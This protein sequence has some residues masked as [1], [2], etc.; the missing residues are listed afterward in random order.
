MKMIR[1][2]MLAS[3]M[4]ASAGLFALRLFF[5]A[6]EAVSSSGFA[7]A[8]YVQM[9]CHFGI[10]LMVSEMSSKRAG[11]RLERMAQTDVLTG[12]GNRRWLVSQLP[13]HLPPGSA[14]L[15]LDLDHFKQINDRLGHA[16]G[17]RALI[18]FADCLR[19]QLRGTDLWA[20]M[21]G[22]EFA[23]YLPEAKPERARAV[24][25]RLCAAAAAI[26][27]EDGAGGQSVAVSVSIGVACVDAPGTPW[28]AW[29]SR[30]DEALYA[31]KRAGR[32]RVVTYTPAG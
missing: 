26:R 9:F 25:E 31:A 3:L 8:F 18:A 11:V 7:A 2:L 24:A 23:V 19:G 15:Q 17:D 10:A 4:L 13:E 5:I 16:A 1:G 12:A 29:L 22:E 6:T 28:S 30:A 21:G 20:R 14:V 27:L 32:N